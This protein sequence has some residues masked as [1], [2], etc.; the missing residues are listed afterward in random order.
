M[1]KDPL[2]FSNMFP[3]PK[4]TSRNDPLSLS[5]MIGNQRPWKMNLGVDISN[6][7]YYPNPYRTQR[8]ARRAAKPQSRF[9]RQSPQ[10]SR[11]RGRY[12]VAVEQDGV[13]RVRNFNSQVE[14]RAF[15][16]KL[17]ASGQFDNVSQVRER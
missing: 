15:R 10:Q 2:A 16:R 3:Q 17:E 8:P 1:K 11:P 6:P 9:T 4:R 12:F 13:Q 14:A 7:A 5:N